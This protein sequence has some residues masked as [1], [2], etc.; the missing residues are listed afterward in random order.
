MIRLALQRR[1]EAIDC[2]SDE[3]EEPSVK[4]FS[5]QDAPQ[6]PSEDAPIT[7]DQIIM[8]NNKCGMR[9]MDGSESSGSSSS[10]GFKD[11]IVLDEE[12]P[13]MNQEIE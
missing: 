4:A 2:E 6:G 12:Q 13:P 7:L 5:T 3:D 10:D 11:M 1:T 8:A 9:W